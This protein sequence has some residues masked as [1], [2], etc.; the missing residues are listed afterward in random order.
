LEEEEEEEEEEGEGEGEEGIFKLFLTL[1]GKFS[2]T[3]RRAIC[4]VRLKP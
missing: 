2:L 3:S 4:S 1:Y